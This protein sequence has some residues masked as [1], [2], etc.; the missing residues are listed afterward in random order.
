MGWINVIT[1]PHN[2]I[3]KVAF[4]RDEFHEEVV[5]AES[6]ATGT[7]FRSANLSNLNYT[8]F[9]LL[10]TKLRLPTSI[11]IYPAFLRGRFLA[12][13]YP[14]A[15]PHLQPLTDFSLHIFYYPITA[16]FSRTRKRDN[17]HPKEKT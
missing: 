10:S 13:S 1:S 5:S 11:L 7:T 15:F 2:L 9:V 16:T 14:T 8:K 12:P 6:E 4:C 3:P 17:I